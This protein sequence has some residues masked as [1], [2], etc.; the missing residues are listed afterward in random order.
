MKQN[1]Q[2][3]QEKEPFGQEFYI[4]SFFCNVDPLSNEF[5]P[6]CANSE[7]CKSKWAAGSVPTGPETQ[8]LRQGGLFK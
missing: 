2:G 3:N 8:H 5:P 6:S 7:H 1:R 4:L